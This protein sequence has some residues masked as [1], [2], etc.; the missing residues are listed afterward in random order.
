MPV[1]MRHVEQEVSHSLLN[2]EL[3]EYAATLVKDGAYLP[4]ADGEQGDKIKAGD[5]LIPNEATYAAGVL[6]P[7]THVHVIRT[8]D[9]AGIVWGAFYAPDGSKRSQ[10]F[11]PDAFV[12]KFEPEPTPLAKAATAKTTKTST[13]VAKP[14][15]KAKR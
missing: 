1:L 3:A 2:S 14:A 6:A 11:V 12:G 15:P 4:G 7:D 9:Y 5:N 13:K 10:F 8:I